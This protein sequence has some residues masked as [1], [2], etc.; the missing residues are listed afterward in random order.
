MAANTVRKGLGV[1]IVIGFAGFLAW[2][3]WPRPLP[4]DIAE[5]KP[6]PMHVAITD[7]GQTRVKDVYRVSA[8]VA[9]RV[10]RIEADVGDTVV[11]GESVVVHLLPSAPAFLDARAL[12]EAEAGVRAAE[13]A[14]QLAQAERRRAVAEVEYSQLEVDRVRDLVKRQAK[15]VAELDRVELSLKIAK[16]ADAR[17]IAAIN[18]RRA[19]LETAK[20]VLIDPATPESVEAGR[21]AGVVGIKAPVS[22]RVLAVLRESEGVVTAGTPLIELGDPTRLEVVVDLLTTSAVK[23]SPGD[24]VE[25]VEWGGD[26]V[27]K[28]RVSR[29]EPTGFTKV[30]SLGIEEQRVN[31]IIEP[32]AGA[33]GWSRLGHGFRVE[34][35]IIVWSADSVL[36]VPAGALFRLDRD[37]AV[38]KLVD[39]TARLQAVKVGHV[40]D[41]WGEITSG[42]AAGDTVIVHPARA[43]EDGLAVAARKKLSP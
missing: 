14:V 17:A 40:S 24:P 3:F 11:A 23:V 26:D 8:P 30:S 36:R 41:A 20:A 6:G 9:G 5:T 34:T 7:E 43:V 35:R 38:F 32:E 27:L 13:A 31:V 2:A 21:T 28:G 18:Q 25:I 29:V 12:S 1:V 19:E 15:S 39:G 16:A 10:L 37:W 22:G 42:L 33:A 4:V